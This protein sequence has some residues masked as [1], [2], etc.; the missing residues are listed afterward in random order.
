[1]SDIVYWLPFLYQETVDFVFQLASKYHGYSTSVHSY[2]FCPQLAELYNLDFTLY[3]I[4]FNCVLGP[5]Q[6]LQLKKTHDF[7]HHLVE[8]YCRIFFATRNFLLFHIHAFMWYSCR[9]RKPLVL[10]DVQWYDWTINF[11]MVL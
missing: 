2:E 9:F 3:P 5:C 4:Y 7:L 1:M 8:K 11:S 6:K 10:L